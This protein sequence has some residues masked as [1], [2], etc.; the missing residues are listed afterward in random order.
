[1]GGS[2]LRGERIHLGAY[3]AAVLAPVSLCVG[4]VAVFQGAEK[5][6]V[7]EA[8]GDSAGAFADPGAVLHL[9]RRVWKVTGLGEYCDLL[10]CRGG[11]VCV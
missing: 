5:L 2:L 3:E 7:R 11:S 1:M 4:A 10:C 8:D 6:L 9:Q